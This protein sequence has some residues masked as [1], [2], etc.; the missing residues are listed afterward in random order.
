MIGPHGENCRERAIDGT[1]E[2]CLHNGVGGITRTGP[3]GDR[4]KRCYGCYR[5]SNPSNL[6]CPPRTLRGKA[7]GSCSQRKCH[8]KPDARFMLQSE[9]GCKC[10]CCDKGKL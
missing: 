8:G 5:Q 4:S 10:K 7:P 9:Q 3:E 2:Q 1:K 6:T